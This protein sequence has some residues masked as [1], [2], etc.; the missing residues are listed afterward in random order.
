VQCQKTPHPFVKTAA[1]A[2]Q[3]VWDENRWRTLKLN[4]HIAAISQQARKLIASAEVRLPKV[5]ALHR[6]SRNVPWATQRTGA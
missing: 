2:E 3:Y 6:T 5:V 1:A 4:A